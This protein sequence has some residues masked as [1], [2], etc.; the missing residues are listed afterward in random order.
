MAMNNDPEYETEVVAVVP[1]HLEPAWYEFIYMKCQKTEHKSPDTGETRPTYTHHWLGTGNAQS[2]ETGEPFALRQITGRIPSQKSNL[3][4]LILALTGRVVRDGQ[5]LPLR[6]MEGRHARL[7]L[8]INE[9]GYNTVEKVQPAATATPATAK[10]AP[11][12]FAGMSPDIR[13]ML[14]AALAAQAAAEPPTPTEPPAGD[15]LTEA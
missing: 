10:P 3:G 9:S 13:A 8:D 5:P 14:T 12:P 11:D 1:D 7:L 15:E 6:E 4:K 2:P